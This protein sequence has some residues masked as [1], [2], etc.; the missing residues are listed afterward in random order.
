MFDVAKLNTGQ[1]VQLLKDGV[2]VGF[3]D[4]LWSLVGTPIQARPRQ[5]EIR[6]VRTT[7][8]AKRYSFKE[9]DHA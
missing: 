3:A 6:W 1:L 9:N 7:S 2:R 8:I 4:G 5:Q